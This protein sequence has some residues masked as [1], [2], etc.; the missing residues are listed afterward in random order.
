MSLTALSVS[1][2]RFLPSVSSSKMNGS[3]FA[4]ALASAISKSFAQDA[5]PQLATKSHD[6][7]VT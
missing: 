3:R 1:A 5:V 4:Q 7:K 2:Q 6:S